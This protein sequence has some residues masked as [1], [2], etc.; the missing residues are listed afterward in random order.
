MAPTLWRVFPWHPAARSGEP[1][2]PQHLSAQSGNGRFDLPRDAGVSTWYFAESQEHAVAENLQH[3]R[4]RN[5]IDD[6]LLERGWRLALCSVQ[7]PPAVRIA[8]LCD[9]SELA[10]RSIAPDRLAFSERG[11]TRRIAKDLY[12]DASL[13]GFRWWSALR[14]EWHT[15]VLF[16]DRLQ[17]G[18]LRFGRPEPLR[19]STPAV[20]TAAHALGIELR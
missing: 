9:P 10:R 13:S 7:A 6:F 15:V 17:P 1:F 4:N 18:S 11:V 16:S 12:D 2:S 20:A 14:G 8:D 19:P 5:L 3:L